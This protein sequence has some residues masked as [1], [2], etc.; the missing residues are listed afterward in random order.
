MKLGKQ[1]N[2]Q[3]MIYKK[4]SMKK[5][6]ENVNK[7]DAIIDNNNMERKENEYIKIN[8]LESM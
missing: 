3:V 4:L 5:M 7:K 2:I 1:M 6:E 8:R